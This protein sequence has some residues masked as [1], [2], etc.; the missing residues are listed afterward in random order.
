MVKIWGDKWHR[1]PTTF[2]VQSPRRLLEAN[3]KVNEHI[4]HG[5]KWWNTELRREIFIKDEVGA[6]CKLTLSCHSQRDATIWRGTTKGELT[7][8]SAYHMKKE[9]QDLLR[10]DG[11]DSSGGNEIWSLIWNLKM[12]MWRACHNVLPTK[13]NLLKRGIVNKL[14]SPIYGIQK[15]ST[16]HIPWCWPS[17]MDV[18]RVCGGKFQKISCGRCR[19][20]DYLQD[21]EGFSSKCTIEYF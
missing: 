19:R 2:F 6:I 21:V 3:D 14:S 7:V 5:T 9:R 10:G 17:A 11:S 16:L 18:W 8:R 4:D 1:N 20:S 15:E 12:F 13:E